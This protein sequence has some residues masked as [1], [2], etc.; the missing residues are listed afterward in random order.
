MLALKEVDLVEYTKFIGNFKNLPI[1]FNPDL[2]D[3]LSKFDFSVKYYILKS[4][5]NF[6]GFMPIFTKKN[7]N[8]SIP[9]FS[10]GLL[11]DKPIEVSL[12]SELRLLLKNRF[13]NFHV[14]I[15]S[16]KN[17]YI[18]PTKEYAE[19][20]LKNSVDEQ[21]SFFKSKLRSQI[22]KSIKNGL[23]SKIG[24]IELLDDF[25]D[26]YSKNMYD[27]GSP[28]Y[29]KE[30]FNKFL[31]SNIHSKIFV[32]NYNDS[33]VASSIC[34]SFGKVNEVVWASSLKS[35]NYLSSNMFLYWKMIEYSISVNYSVFSF[36]RSDPKSSQLKFKKQW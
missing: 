18:S 32:V 7:Q 20:N 16:L 4:N 23:K 15:I 10:Y 28:V 36:G 29:S 17:C 31:L 6:I 21:M 12:I 5:E 33:P 35:F 24:G 19:L 34:V 26:I 14:K 25:Y 11:I 22:K 3:F 8:Y 1:S 13:K 30:F 2:I 9:F 27:I